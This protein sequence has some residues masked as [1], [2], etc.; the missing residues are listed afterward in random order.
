MQNHYQVKFINQGELHYGTVDSYSPEAKQ[1]ALENKILVEDAIYPQYWTLE[2][3]D[4]SDVPIGRFDDD[5]EYWQYVKRF[6]DNAINVSNSRQGC[7]V[8]K[9]IKFQVAD[10]YAYYVIARV[11]KKTVKLEWRGFSM[12]RYVEPVLGF[13]GTMDK[14]RLEQIIGFEDNLTSLFGGKSG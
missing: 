3:K 9:L 1:A 7:K 4:I 12:D 6:H 10:G 14:E 8:G 5:D 2:E 11:N 13:E